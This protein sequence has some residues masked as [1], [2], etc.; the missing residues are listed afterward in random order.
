[1]FCLKGDGLHPDHPLF[2]RPSLQDLFKHEAPS[3]DFNFIK[4]KRIRH[5]YAKYQQKK[6]KLDWIAYLLSLLNWILNSFVL[7]GIILLPMVIVNNYNYTTGT[8]F[9][10]NNYT[11]L[12]TIT[13]TVNTIVNQTNTVT[14]TV[15]LTALENVVTVL[16]NGNSAQITNIQ[17]TLNGIENTL[18]NVMD[19]VVNLDIFLS[20]LPGLLNGAGNQDKLTE[21]L[22]LINAILTA[23][24]GL[25][26]G[27]NQP[28]DISGLVGLGDNP[29]GQ[30]EY[31]EI[32]MENDAIIINDPHDSHINTV[33]L[34]YYTK[35]SKLGRS[36]KSV[37]NYDACLSPT[38]NHALIKVK[39]MLENLHNS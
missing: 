29:E 31:I 21:L 17:N 12:T 33:M 26:F 19:D 39:N 38:K 35:H 20:G 28:L 23:R 6:W 9:T 1:M 13:N 4:D 15:D 32:D 11:Q 36:L 3:Y 5:Y 14:T 30:V 2:E 27:G 34:D 8:V 10:T 22:N 16:E 37:T 24:S 18:N 7:A 25:F